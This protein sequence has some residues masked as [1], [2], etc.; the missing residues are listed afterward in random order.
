MSSSWHTVITQWIIKTKHQSPS[1][2]KVSL[3]LAKLSWVGLERKSSIHGGKTSLVHW[4]PVWKTEGW[5]RK[6]FWSWGCR[7]E[8]PAGMHL[9]EMTKRENTTVVLCHFKKN[10]LPLPIFQVWKDYYF[11]TFARQLWSFLECKLGYI[12]PFQPRPSGSYIFWKMH[13]DCSPGL[14]ASDTA[15]FLICILLV[16]ASPTPGPTTSTV[17]AVALPVLWPLLPG[18]TP[19]PK[20]SYFLSMNL[21][22]FSRLQISGGARNKNTD[23]TWEYPFFMTMKATFQ[24]SRG[25][26]SWEKMNSV[27]TDEIWIQWN[28]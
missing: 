3:S 21:N 12:S 14:K 20:L 18:N 24:F 23:L 28:I 16:L 1:R 17:P 4:T 19:S 15:S 22:Q 10:F 7:W 9:F 13:R 11:F 6:V 5:K 27:H 2:R 26:N 8:H 25:I